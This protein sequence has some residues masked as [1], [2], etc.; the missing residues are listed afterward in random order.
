MGLPVMMIVLTSLYAGRLDRGWRWGLLLAVGVMMAAL[1]MV[2]LS[3][4]WLVM[5]LSYVWSKHARR[6]F[7]SKAMRLIV[8]S[9]V[10][11]VTLVIF[12]FGQV[13]LQQLI[14]GVIAIFIYVVWLKRH[15]FYLR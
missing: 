10:G 5:S 12:S 15:R 6:L 7:S 8:G 4:S 2:P 3:I 14:Y 1:F 13:Y 11:S 9:I